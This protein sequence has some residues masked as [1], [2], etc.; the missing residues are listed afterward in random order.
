[1]FGASAG[2]CFGRKADQSDSE[3]RISRAILPLNSGDPDYPVFG[4]CSWH[5]DTNRR[6]PST[7]PKYFIERFISYKDLEID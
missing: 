5:P 6:D 1:M 7:R 3:S 2:A 4:V